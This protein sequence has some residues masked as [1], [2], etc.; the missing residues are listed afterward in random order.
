MLWE[1]NTMVFYNLA[2]KEKGMDTL[3]GE[4]ILS[5][6]FYIPSEKGSTLKWKDMLPLETKSFILESKRKGFAVTVSQ[7]MILDKEQS[8]YPYL[9]EQIIHHY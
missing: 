4:I 5:N 8:P 6:L 3:S 7:I 9:S 1:M 2:K